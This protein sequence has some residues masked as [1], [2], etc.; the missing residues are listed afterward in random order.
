[1][2]QELLKF[3]GVALLAWAAFDIYA[4]HTWLPRKIERA[5]EPAL[6]WS[7]IGF[8]LCLAAVLFAV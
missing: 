4:G 5:K 2:V 1:M 6:F 3:A 7:V 8:W